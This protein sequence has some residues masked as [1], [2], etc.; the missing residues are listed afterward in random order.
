M[1]RPVAAIAAALALVLGLSGCGAA[2]STQTQP[3]DKTATA[4]QTPKKNS[5]D[6]IVKHM[7]DEAGITGED[8]KGVADWTVTNII[9]DLPKP[10][11]RAAG[12]W[13]FRR[14]QHK[15]HNNRE[16]RSR[17]IRLFGC[18]HRLPVAAHP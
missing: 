6:N 8:G 17:Q 5:R 18:R 12:A 7:G 9:P 4:S 13:P 3:A 16:I 11:A 14:T 1:K 15:R 10:R 2:N